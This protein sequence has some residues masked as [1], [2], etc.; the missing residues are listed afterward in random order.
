MSACID[1]ELPKPRDHVLS[2]SDAQAAEYH[3]SEGT[4]GPDT[5]GFIQRGL[6]KNDSMVFENALV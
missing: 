1:Q 6:G 2:L 4:S 3:E 5:P